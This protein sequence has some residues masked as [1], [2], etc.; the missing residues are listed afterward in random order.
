M[1]I[2]VG[3]G[4]DIRKRVGCIEDLDYRSGQKATP[5]IDSGI[6]RVYLPND[7]RSL[8]KLYIL[9][10]A[11]F[12]HYYWIILAQFS[13]CYIDD[14]MSLPN[15]RGSWRVLCCNSKTESAVLLAVLP[16]T[17]LKAETNPQFFNDLRKEYLNIPLV[18]M[19]D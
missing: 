12:T 14:L 3:S 5:R 17:P 2:V 19:L 1:G 9:L 6:Y 8:T 11:Y 4:Y 15:T 16:V 18:A 13:K 7:P 10:T